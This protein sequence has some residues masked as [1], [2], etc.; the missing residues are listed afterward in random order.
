MTTQ[1]PVTA[2]RP[3]YG[4]H[5]GKFVQAAQAILAPAVGM[6][7]KI[8]TRDLAREVKDDGVFRVYLWSGFFG[9]VRDVRPP[10]RVF[11]RFKL[12]CQ[13]LAFRPRGD[14]VVLTD[15]DTGFVLAELFPHALFVHVDLMHCTCPAE[16]KLLEAIFGWVATRDMPQ[17]KP[18]SPEESAQAMGQ[19]YAAFHEAACARVR[20]EREALT[21]RREQLIGEAEESRKELEEARETLGVLQGVALDEQR[22]AIEIQHLLDHPLVEEVVVTQDGLVVF[23]APLHVVDRRDPAAQCLRL[24]G[25]YRLRIPIVA[26]HNDIVA[27]NLDRFDGRNQGPHIGPRGWVCM[28]NVENTIQQ[29]LIAGEYA[30]IATLMLEFLQRAKPGDGWVESSMDGF[31]IVAPTPAS[32][33]A[34]V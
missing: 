19:A 22:I 20:S 32:V 18:P 10:A 31:P 21:S 7:V 12:C 15:P 4:K 17:A 29:L 16:P 24:L 26:N 11:G 28:G 23:T 9:T 14:G 34:S 8:I 30:M 1:F 27:I 3:W 6:H 33:P 13:N 25:R 2:V 5:E